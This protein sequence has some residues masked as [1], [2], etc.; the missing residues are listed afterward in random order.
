MKYDTIIKDGKV[1]IPK[2]GL[3]DAAIAIN[4]GKVAAIFED[5]SGLEAQE[6]I[7][8]AGKY[9][10]PGVIDPH[11]HWG[12]TTTVADQCESESRSAAIGGVTTLLVYLTI[13]RYTDE[14]ISRQRDEAQRLSHIDFSIQPMMIKDDDIKNVERVVREWGISSFKMLTTRKA[15][16][17]PSGIAGLATTQLI[18]PFTDGFFYDALSEM[19]KFKRVVACIH[20]ENFEIMERLGPRVRSSGEE[21]LPAWDHT[22]PDFAEAESTARVC[23]FSKVTGCP[24]YV[25]HMSVKSAVEELVRFKHQNVRVYG[26]TCPHYLVLNIDSPIGS[27]GKVNPPL[28]SREHNEALWQA[29]ANGDL[30]TVG[31]DTAVPK[32]ENK[33]GDIWTAL[34]GFGGAAM[35][36]PILLSEGVHKGRISLERVVEVTSYNVANVFNLYP[37][38]GTIMVGSDADL[39]IVDLNLEK[40]VTPEVLQSWADFSV[41]DG[42]KV[43]GWPVMT[44]VR[45]KVVMRDG[46]VVGPRGHGQYIKRNAF[47]SSL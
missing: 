9:I 32:V 25:V 24:V 8:A 42:W 39:A 35:I 3:V 11:M 19:A 45:G 30:D 40:V 13:E 37:R 34:P 16:V 38:K 18:Q 36:L 5:T 44:F 21:G 4:D 31:S 1:V 22:R 7:S 47:L 28:R 41:Y 12:Y 10:L 29:L 33:R 23:Y 20:A 6:V 14:L 27:L 2:V 43:K 26:E 15:E 17:H 46:Q